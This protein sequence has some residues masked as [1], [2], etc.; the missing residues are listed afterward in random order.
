VRGDDSYAEKVGAV[1][2]FVAADVA[3]ADQQ[4]RSS[5]SG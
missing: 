2:A 1:Q 5:A 4:A 3:R